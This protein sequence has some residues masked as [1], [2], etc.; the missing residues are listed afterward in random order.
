MKN[1]LIGT[2]MALALTV[3]TQAFGQ[4]H[5]HTPQAELVDSTSKDAIEVFS[6]TTSADTTVS[7]RS[8]TRTI[9]TPWKTVTTTYDEDIDSVDD[10][11]D[12][13]AEVLNVLPWG[14]IIS[15]FVILLLVVLLPFILMIIAAIIVIRHNRKRREQR[16]MNMAQGGPQPGAAPQPGDAPQPGAAPRFN[17]SS[18]ADW[19]QD[20]QSIED[21][22]QKG[23]RQCFV[24]VGLMIFLGLAAGEV[25]FGIG[26][27]VL[28]I[29]LGKIFGARKARQMRDEEKFDKSEEDRL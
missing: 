12:G 8:V 15:V 10:D 2:M 28:C 7:K 9:S 25:G 21:D 13:L 18:A 14:V 27:L 3:S 4:K 22:Y 5:R 11:L 26:A 1:L 29:G 17:S 24:G 19:T 20:S 6:D 16:M 23:L